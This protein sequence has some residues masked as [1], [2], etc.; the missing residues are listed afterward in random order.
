MPALFDTKVI[1]PVTGDSLLITV[2]VHIQPS[3]TR[4]YVDGSEFKSFAGDDETDLGDATKF[5]QKKIRVHT[6]I[7]DKST[8]TD[9]IK[10]QHLAQYG[11][12]MVKRVVNTTASEEGELFDVFTDIMVF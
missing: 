11:D 7:Q 8:N 3:T 6:T 9:D 10:A 2:K 12:K 4:I 1:F 5:K